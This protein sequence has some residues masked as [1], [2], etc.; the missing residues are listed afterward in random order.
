MYEKKIGLKV[1]K[2]REMQGL[3]TTELAKRVGVSQAQISRLEN[4]LQGFRSSTLSKIADAL[5][6]RPAYFWQEENEG[7]SPDNPEIFGAPG[8]LGKAL[9]NPEF[10]DVAERAAKVFVADR[11]SFGKIRRAVDTAGD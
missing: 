1:N 10:R 8:T 7:A 11:E 5:G 6:V 3:T 4:G 2:L 9:A